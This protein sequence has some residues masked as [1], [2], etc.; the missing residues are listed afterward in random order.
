MYD[1]RPDTKFL[2]LL[3]HAR[4]DDNRGDFVYHLVPWAF[5]TLGMVLRICATYLLVIKT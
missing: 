5:N 4:C 2:C 1:A 3:L